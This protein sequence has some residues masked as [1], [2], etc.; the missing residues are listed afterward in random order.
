MANEHLAAAAMTADDV[1]RFYSRAVADPE[2]GCLEWI[3]AGDGYGSF[4]LRG[5]GQM[6]AHRLAYALVHGEILEETIDHLCRNR[7]C[8][9]PEHLEAVSNRVN[10]LRGVGL[11]AMNAIKNHCDK[12]HPFTPENTSMRVSR[13]R[14][15]RRCLECDRQLQRS[16]YYRRSGNEWYGAARRRSTRAKHVESVG[17]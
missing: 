3:S 7:A 13:G 17:E 12:S 6:P 2:T 9:N 15:F 16:I 10:V 5:F 1:A 11:S 14:E 4:C 8:I